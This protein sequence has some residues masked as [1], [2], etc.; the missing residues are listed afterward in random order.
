MPSLKRKLT[1]PVLFGPLL[2][3]EL[4]GREIVGRDDFACAQLSCPNQIERTIDNAPDI[5]DANLWMVGKV[6]NASCE[7][8]FKSR[9]YFVEV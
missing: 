7:I 4:P 9:V 2:P 6:L 1:V 3:V 8:T 5:G